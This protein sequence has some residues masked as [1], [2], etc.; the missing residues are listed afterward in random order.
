MAEKDYSE[1]RKGKR[2]FLTDEEIEKE[3]EYCRKYAGFSS[4]TFEERWELINE[5]EAGRYKPVPKE[6]QKRM[7][8]ERKHNTQKAIDLFGWG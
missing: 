8:E 6:E 7:I 5:A 4:L 1:Y 2:Q 3:L